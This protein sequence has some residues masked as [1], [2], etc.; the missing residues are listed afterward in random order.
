MYVAPELLV[1]G[2][3]QHWEFVSVH[4]QFLAFLAQDGGIYLPLKRAAEVWDVL[5]QNP[6]ACADDRTVSNGG[7]ILSLSSSYSHSLSAPPIPPP[8]PLPTLLLP[9]ESLQMV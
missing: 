6:N 7:T 9:T 8:L 2:R 5:I 4:L 3:Y 1:D